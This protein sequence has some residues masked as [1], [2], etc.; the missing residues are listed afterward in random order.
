MLVAKPCFVFRDHCGPITMLANPERV[1]PLAAATNVHG[2]RRRSSFV[3]IQNLAHHNLQFTKLLTASNDGFEGCV[4]APPVTGAFGFSRVRRGTAKPL[5]C[6]V[7][8]QD[9][10]MLRCHPRPLELH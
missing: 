1:A 8:H 2:A 7:T 6:G 3:L 9:E 4:G 5:T 10:T